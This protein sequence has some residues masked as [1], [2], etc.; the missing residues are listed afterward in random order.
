VYASV[1]LQAKCADFL[2]AYL[3]GNSLQL[4]QQTTTSLVLQDRRRAAIHSYLRTLPPDTFR[5]LAQLKRQRVQHVYRPVPVYSMCVLKRFKSPECTS[6]AVYK[7]YAERDGG[8]HFLLSAA[9]DVA[10]GRFVVTADEARSCVPAAVSSQD[11]VASLQSNALDTLFTMYDNGLECAGLASAN[12]ALPGVRRRE[13]GVVSYSM[14]LT[15]RSPR[16][17]IGIF[18]KFPFKSWPEPSAEPSEAIAAAG[19]GGGGV[20]GGGGG[21]GGGRGGGESSIEA[22]HGHGNGVVGRGERRAGVG[23][24]GGA[25]YEDGYA[26]EDL[27]GGHRIR[28]ARFYDHFFFNSFIFP[29]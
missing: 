27:V 7:L 1:E 9:R 6:W 24:G 14:N 18:P 2:V 21:E 4:L 19:D 12:A 5:L 3:G 15:G 29:S 28:K 20:G 8:L 13:I 10:T 17:I 22:G 26:D 23:R 16:N 25:W 11:V